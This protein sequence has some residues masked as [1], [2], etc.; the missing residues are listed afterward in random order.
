MVLKARLKEHAGLA[1]FAAAAIVFAGLSLG[2]ER[3]TLI[4][5]PVVKQLL[6][7]G[8]AVTSHDI[9]WIREANVRPVQPP[10]L[11]GYARTTLYP[12][13]VLSPEE[14][15]H[16]VQPGVMVAVAP[17]NAVDGNVAMVGHDVD[18]LILG[19]SGG[20]L[21]QSGPLVVVGRSGSGSVNLTMSFRKALSYESHKT[22]GT[23]TLVGIQS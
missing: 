16:Q 3:S 9:T 18:V 23:V 20:V 4:R 14:V 6:P 7:V 13:Q 2:A 11:V 15:G 19:K 17:A 1:A 22:L 12:G 10:Q 5:V 8:G 21:W